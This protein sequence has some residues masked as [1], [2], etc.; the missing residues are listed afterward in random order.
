MDHLGAVRPYPTQASWSINR[1]VARKGWSVF[2]KLLATDA[3][4]LLSSLSFVIDGRIVNQSFC[5]TQTIKSALSIMNLLRIVHEAYDLSS[6][7]SVQMTF[8]D[9]L[10]C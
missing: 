2:E 7:V 1:P 3:W 4:S 9:G 5:V 6:F 10:F 8:L